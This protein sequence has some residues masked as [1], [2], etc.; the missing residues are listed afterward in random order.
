ME[1]TRELDLDRVK[2]VL[3][4][5][6]KMTREDERRVF[7]GQYVA[8]QPSLDGTHM[9][10]MGKLGAYEGE[11]CRKALDQLGDRL[12]PAGETRP[13]PGHRRAL[14]LTALCQDELDRDP[15]SGP[16]TD[17]PNASSSGKRREPL[18]MVVAHHPLA[19]ESGYEQGAG[20]LAGGRVGPDTIDMLTCRGRVEHV[21]VGGQSVTYHGST[22]SIRPSLRRAVLARDD[23]CTIDGGTS[24][25]R[26]EVHYIICRSGGGDHSAENLTTLCWWHHHVAIHRRGMR[27]D[28]QTPPRRRRLLPPRARCGYQPPGPDPHTVAIL[29]ILEQHA[30]R[31]PP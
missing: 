13:D 24:T 21:T 23:G 8:L 11:L 3:Q 29:R 25:Y 26:L 19:E 16:R 28:P 17:N 2:R 15:N 20:V 6:R 31:S 14:A 12:I 27:I 10:V 4:Q 30:N 5:R 22:S 9:R 7:E 18:L 1:A